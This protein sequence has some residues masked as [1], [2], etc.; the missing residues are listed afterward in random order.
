MLKRYAGLTILS[1]F[2]GV[3]T[4]VTFYPILETWNN[5]RMRA[6]AKFGI[7]VC[8]GLVVFLGWFIENQRVFVAD[9]QTRADRVSVLAGLSYMV[10]YVTYGAGVVLGYILG[11][12]FGYPQERK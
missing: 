11:D 8:V 2:T 12:R 7:G 5:E 3:V 4:H 9:E 10:A 6:F 1:L